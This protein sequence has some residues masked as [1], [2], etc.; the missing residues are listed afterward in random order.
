MHTHTCLK[1]HPQSSRIVCH[2]T[3]NSTTL[4]NVCFKPTR[5]MRGIFTPSLKTIADII[6]LFSAET[7]CLETQIWGLIFNY[8]SGCALSSW[9][10]FRQKITNLTPYPPIL[11]WIH[12]FSQRL[13]VKKFTSPPYFFLGR[14][15]IGL[16]FKFTDFIWAENFWGNR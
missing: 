12:R 1:S 3:P 15:Q 14:V 8:F 4:E 5:D 2:A 6:C 16:V 7:N 10:H 11:F 9:R 13:A